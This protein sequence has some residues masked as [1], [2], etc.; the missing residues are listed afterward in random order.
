MAGNFA[1]GLFCERLKFP[2][3]SPPCRVPCQF[4]RST[5]SH[6]PHL[7]RRPPPIIP[8]ELPSATTLG[9]GLSSRGHKPYYLELS[10]FLQPPFSWLSPLAIFFLWLS[11]AISPPGS[12]C[13]PL[14]V[15]GL[16]LSCLQTQIV[17]TPRV[18]FK[19]LPPGYTTT[20][21]TKR[22]NLVGSQAPQNKGSANG[23]CHDQS[24]QN[25]V[26]LLFTS[27]SLC[28]VLTPSQRI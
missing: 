16:Q 17:L 14:S 11:G 4:H 26:C 2:Q 27:L 3:N 21:F 10:H 6:S 24:A 12:P 23:S 22:L 25:L 7:H 19:A 18:T 28:I 20:L 5:L 8:L 13:S 15:P 1:R 9:K